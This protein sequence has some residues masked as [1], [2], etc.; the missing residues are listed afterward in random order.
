MGRSTASTRPTAPSSELWAFDTREALRSSAAIDGDGNAYLGS[1]EGKL[2]VLNPDGTLRWAIQLIDE[3]RNDLN[4]S[5][6]LG[7][8]AI[9]LAGESGEVFS[10]PYDYCLRADLD[11]DRCVTDTG[12]QL[13]ASGVQLVYTDRFGGLEPIAPV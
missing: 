10:I 7:L 5:P 6:A 8:E 2:F 13:P 11:D 4:A 9:Y 12:E 3:D 1:G